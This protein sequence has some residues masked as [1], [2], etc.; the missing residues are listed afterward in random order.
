MHS[1]FGTYLVV[2]DRLFGTYNM[3]KPNK[4]I[5]TGLPMGGDFGYNSGNPLGVYLK[6]FKLFAHKFFEVLV[7]PKNIT[8][9]LDEA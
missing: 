4:V 6:V 9:D 7:K 8:A 5:K 2:W 3:P 1:N